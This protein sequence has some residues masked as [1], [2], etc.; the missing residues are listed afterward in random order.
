M[1]QYI[2]KDKKYYIAEH[3][4]IA[5]L[6]VLVVII[7]LANYKLQLEVIELSRENESLTD[8]TEMQQSKIA[9]LEEKLRR[10]E[11]ENGNW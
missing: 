2:Y 6:L 8:L 1:K 5:I 4:I 9:E 3:I 7:S 11:E 10:V